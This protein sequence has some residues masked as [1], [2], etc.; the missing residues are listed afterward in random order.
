MRLLFLR[1]AEPDY[2]IDGITTKGALEADLLSKQIKSLC[3][4]E[5]FVSPLGRAAAT[6]DPCIKT[7]GIKAETLDW[8]MEFPA[9]FDPGS[10]GEETRRAYI[11]ELKKDEKSGKYCTRIIWDM[12]PSYYADHP[13]LFDVTGWRTSDIAKA[14]DAVEI[15]DHVIEK[16]D[17][18]LR[19]HG[20]ER[21][22]SIYNVLNNNGKT[23]AFFCHFGITCVLLSHLW[24]VSPFVPLQFLAM[25]PTSLTEV[26]TEE[27]EKGIAV[28]RTL[29]IGDITHLTMGN[30][31]PSFSARFCECFEN[32]DERH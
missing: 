18:L 17:L 8:L 4:D 21:K 1:H 29:R 32:D 11:N 13:E 23:L 28:F 5:A 14:S 6:A 24:N 25:A 15:Y 19:D 3:I 9:S 16:F 10:A 22:G 27:R 20:Y 30:E 7:L 26:V 12:M 2:K 31:K